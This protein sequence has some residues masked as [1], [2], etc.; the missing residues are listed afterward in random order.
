ML[1]LS[2]ILDRITAPETIAMPAALLANPELTATSKVLWAWLNFNIP[3]IRALARWTGFSRNTVR[4]NL[5]KLEALGWVEQLEP[6]PN[7]SQSYRPRFDSG[8]AAMLPVQLLQA[9]DVRPQGKVI[10]CC[11]Q[12][13]PEC[14]R[15]EGQLRLTRLH[16]SAGVCHNTAKCALKNLVARGWARAEQ[17]HRLAPLVFTLL[18]PVFRRQVGE[19]EAAHRRTQRAPFLGEALAAEGCRLLSPETQYF[20]NARPAGFEHPMT[21]ERLEFDRYYIQAGVAVEFNGPQHDGP[22]AHFPDEQAWRRQRVRDLVKLGLAVERGIKLIVLRPEDLDLVTLRERL[23]GYLP[24]RDLSNHQP[25]VEYLT[26]RYE[27]YRGRLV[28]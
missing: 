15:K 23:R 22:T 6:G 13:V 14:Y 12:L 9:R 20:D 3:S 4:V 10:Y 7:G 28:G 8:P 24:L 26:F 21:G 25:L 17:D 18:N 2:E 16:Q 27:Q 1:K 5:E 19:V 11:L